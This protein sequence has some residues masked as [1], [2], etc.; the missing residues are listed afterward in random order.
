MMTSLDGGDNGDTIATHDN[1]LQTQQFYST[2]IVKIR[3]HGK[4]SVATNPLIARGA[5]GQVD[6]ALLVHRQHRS[7]KHGSS[8]K[9]HSI[10]LAAVKTIPNA[11][12]VT[13]SPTHQKSAASL[14]REAFAELNALRLLNGHDNVTPLLGF[15]SSQ[16]SSTGGGGFGGWDWAYGTVDYQRLSPSSLSL[17]FPYHPIDLHEALMYRRFYTSSNFAS[18]GETCSGDSYLLPK[19]V[20]QSVMNDVLSALCHLHYHCIIH[21][22][23]KPGNLYITRKGQIQLGDFG[24]AKIVPPLDLSPESECHYSDWST[25]KS[26]VN[27]TQGLCTL[28][29]RPPE[30]LLGGTGIINQSHSKE[31]DGVNGAIDIFSAG[32]IFAELL[33]LSGPIFPGQSV[34]DQLGRIFRVLGTPSED[35]WP[36]VTMLP[37]WNKVVFEPN[38]GTGLHQRIG[39][40]NLTDEIDLL[41]KMLVLDPSNRSSAR[42]CLEHFWFRSFKSDCSS[43]T[44]NNCARQGV[45]LSLLPS[46]MQFIDPVYSSPPSE[47]VCVMQG[48]DP[49]VYAEQ[50]ASK[51]AA[52][53]RDFVS[54]LNLTRNLDNM[55]RWTC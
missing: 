50:Y 44:E 30:M 52:N 37:D 31:S 18:D 55:K 8:S 23:L 2:S 12:I 51:R 4:S 20:V 39:R 10:S 11:T 46:H 43:D 53:R 54:N 21:R 9:I 40:D 45:I 34:F 35:N 49:L 28:Q 1:K 13:G 6:I 7:S 14:T 36:R 17:V 38:E 42:H 15:F 48:K 47:K 3:N 27:L 16:D 32:C 41:S 29:Y 25:F 26:N 24:L 5:F 22:D 19:L 33:T